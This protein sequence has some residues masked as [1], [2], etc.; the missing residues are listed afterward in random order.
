MIIIAGPK[1]IAVDIDDTLAMWD[2]ENYHAHQEH[3]TLIKQFHKRGHK[4][5]AWSAGGAEWA[6]HVVR[7]F[8]LE[9]YFE[10]AIGKFDWFIDDKPSS[11][12]LPEANRIY[13]EESKEERIKI[14]A[15]GVQTDSDGK[16]EFFNRESSIS[17]RI[18]EGRAR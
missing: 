11:A 2:G 1:T 14:R 16:M 12:F 18:A 3:I 15:Y 5:I 6:A 9:E 8:G 7:E 13:L 10:A 4:L 17:T